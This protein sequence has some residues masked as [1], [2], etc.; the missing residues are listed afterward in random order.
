MVSNAH[1]GIELKYS[2]CATS[3]A[4][5]CADA[6]LSSSPL[7]RF[8]PAVP[9][10]ALERYG[11]EAGGGKQGDAVRRTGGRGARL[12]WPVTWWMPQ[13]PWM[14]KPPRRL[15]KCRP[16]FC[17]KSRVS[18]EE[19]THQTMRV[20]GMRVVLGSGARSAA[21]SAPWAGSWWRRFYAPLKSCSDGSA[22][23]S[24]GDASTRRSNPAL[25]QVPFPAVATLP[26]AAQNLLTQVPLPAV[27][28]FLRAAQILL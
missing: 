9:L 8:A 20:G 25:T 18:Q 1:S 17:L 22:S 27:A 14:L 3:A 26:R 5:I 10:V 28:T 21:C 7:R 4:A 23:F 2:V 15:P 6:L 11:G 24:S 12:L 19:P 16:H 13:S